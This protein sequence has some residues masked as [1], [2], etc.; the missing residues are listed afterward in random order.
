MKKII[1]KITIISTIK[2]VNYLT[3]KSFIIFN[4]LKEILRLVFFSKTFVIIKIIFLVK[5]I[6]D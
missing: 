4:Y 3:L 2:K 6:L 5:F 1:N